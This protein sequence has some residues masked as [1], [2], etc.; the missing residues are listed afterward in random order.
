MPLTIKSRFDDYQVLFGESGAI[1]RFLSNEHAMFIV[2]EKVMSLYKGNS[3]SAIPLEKTITVVAKEKSKTLPEIERV[4]RFLIK[5][6]AK[7]DTLLVAVGG[8]VIQD[9][10]G[11]V[12]STLY[13]GIKWTFVPTTLLAQADS[14]IGS[15]TSVNLGKFKSLLGTFYPPEEICLDVSFLSTL[16][17]SDYFSGLGEIAKLAI[18]DGQ[19]SVEWFEHI[20]PS[21]LRRERK[22]TTEAI[23]RALRIKKRFIEVDELDKGIRNYLNFGHCFG[24]AVE[25]ATNY[26]VPHGQAVSI[27]MILA[28]AVA[29]NRGLIDEKRFMR[30]SVLVESIVSFDLRKLKLAPVKMIEAIQRDKKRVGKGLALIM[31][32]DGYKMKKVDDMSP[33]EVKSG[34]FKTCGKKV[35]SVLKWKSF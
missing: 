9:I 14:C 27:G 26:R 7:K 22:E 6:G 8:G 10:T 33:S 20:L 21:L 34:S 17:I 25:S 32:V 2:D 11:F 31:S 15:K 3:L 18:I 19:E 13:R 1:S 4:Y 28:D 5:I 12:A 30:Q 35:K 24:H 29:L 16:T 23:E